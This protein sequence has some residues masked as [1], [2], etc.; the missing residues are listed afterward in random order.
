M[1]TFSI[2]SLLIGV[3]TFLIWPIMSGSRTPIGGEIAASRELEN[4]RSE[5][6]ALLCMISEMD[7]DPTLQTAV[8][9]TALQHR[10]AE[11]LEG[12][13]TG[14]AHTDPIEPPAWTV[15]AI[16]PLM[17][18]LL[19][20]GITGGATS[21]YQLV[22]WKMKQAQL[23]ETGGIGEPKIPAIDPK[24]M[25]ARLEARLKKNPDDLE[26][27]LMAGRSYMVMERWEDARRAWDQVLSL[28]AHNTIAHYSLGELL[29]RISLPNK[30][31]KPVAEEA[32][33]HFEQALLATPQDPT[34]LWGR[35][36]A[37]VQLG[38]VAEADAA[39]TEAYQGIAPNTPAAEAVKKALESL[40]AGQTLF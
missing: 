12:I 25:V 2:V 37:L 22:H 26:G 23:A 8:T 40:R 18:S 19:V 5:K 31:P 15:R 34:V 29:I 21:I 13:E 36:I 10:L 14:R 20:L 28:D 38:R 33:V 32:L 39:W 6:D 16:N 30:M 35:G 4:L 1:L 17:V 9:Q 27:Q 7:I 3:V 24:A 11:V